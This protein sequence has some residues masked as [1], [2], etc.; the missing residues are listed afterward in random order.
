MRRRLGCGA[1]ESGSGTDAKFGR[2]RCEDADRRAPPVSEREERVAAGL[3]S[4]A[5]ALGKTW[6]WPI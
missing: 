4:V 3:L 6:A 2:G 5:R 1:A